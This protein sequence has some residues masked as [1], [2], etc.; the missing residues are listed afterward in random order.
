MGYSLQKPLLN[1]YCMLVTVK[2]SVEGKQ[3]ILSLPSEAV[4]LRNNYHTEVDANLT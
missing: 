2:Q 4:M 1:P 3:G